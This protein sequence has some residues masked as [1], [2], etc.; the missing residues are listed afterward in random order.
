MRAKYLSVQLQFNPSN[1]EK[2]VRSFSTSLQRIF[3]AHF[4]VPCV[5]I[6][7]FPYCNGGWNNLLWHEAVNSGDT[8][9][10][11]FVN[12]NRGKCTLCG[13]KY[14]NSNLHSKWITVLNYY[15]DLYICHLIKNILVPFFSLSA[16]ND[17]SR[18]QSDQNH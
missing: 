11:D 6:C 1:T 4:A 5:H 8:E 2:L 13:I 7:M 12:M 9:L 17:C 18:L 16:F 14:L 3:A 10:M 15:Y